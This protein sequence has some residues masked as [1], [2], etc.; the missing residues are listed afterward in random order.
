MEEAAISK[1]GYGKKP[2]L[3]CAWLQRTEMADL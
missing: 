2:R 1:A 3:F